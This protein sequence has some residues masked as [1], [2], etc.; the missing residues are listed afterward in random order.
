[1][2]TATETMVR[3]GELAVSKNQAEIL[4]TIGL[5]SCIG[6]ALV[7]RARSL[8][9][10]AHVM[11]PASNASASEPEAKFADTAVPALLERLR[12]LGASP[13]RLEAVLV[14]G[15]RMYSFSSN[16]LD[17]GSRNE[18]ATL[19]QLRRAGVRVAAKET[20]GT[21][22]RTIRVHVDGGLVVCKP[23]GGSEQ[24]LLGARP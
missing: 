23:T 24:V 11:L 14:G 3:M 4:V 2:T 22:G 8:A 18:Q 20:A 5:G 1:V 6:L 13:A 10:L 21:L 7:D 15:A 12:R 9:G 16:A 19:E 17:I